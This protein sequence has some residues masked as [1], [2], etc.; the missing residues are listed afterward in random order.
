MT[1]STIFIFCFM[2]VGH[3]IKNLLCLVNLVVVMCI[4]VFHCSEG[5]RL[6]P[7]YKY[8]SCWLSM[9]IDWCLKF[10]FIFCRCVLKACGFSF[11]LLGHPVI[12]H[13]GMPRSILVHSQNL[14]SLSSCNCKDATLLAR[15]AKSSAYAA[16]FNL[17]IAV[18]KV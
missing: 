8:G 5:T 18:L 16:E 4:C 12:A 15:T 13:L 9:G 11:D 1:V 2:V 17:V 14:P 6:I 3:V 7:R 10:I